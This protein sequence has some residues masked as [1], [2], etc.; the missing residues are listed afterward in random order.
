ME[1]ILSHYLRSGEAFHRMTGGLLLWVNQAAAG[2]REGDGPEWFGEQFVHPVVAKAPFEPSSNA[3]LF[4][5]RHP[6]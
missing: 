3:N 4:V 2:G 1:M 5:Q 6:P